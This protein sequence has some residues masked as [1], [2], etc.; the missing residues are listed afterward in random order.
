MDD[1]EPYYSL[2][3]DLITREKF[4][5]EIRKRREKYGNLLSDEAIAYLIVDEL[6]RNPGN[7]MKIGDLY[8]GIHA[9]VEAEVV[10]IG[11]VEY[12][13]GEDKK[14][15]LLKVLIKDD[16]GECQLLLWNEEIDNLRH[17][18]REGAKVKIVNG[19]V[20]ENVYGL[21]ISL[22]RWGLLVVE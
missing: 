20:R 4:I 11:N 17:Q 14:H 22:G 3:A 16:T 5:E 18:L 1:I 21:Q 13:G 7:R 9:T 8:D 12:V 6:G 10:K 19:Y 15:R 2:I